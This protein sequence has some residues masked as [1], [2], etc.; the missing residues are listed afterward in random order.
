M[1]ILE[2]IHRFSHDGNEAIAYLRYW[3]KDNRPTVDV[4]VVYTTRIN[5][6]VAEATFVQGIRTQRFLKNI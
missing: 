2:N 1:C 3:Y 4:H 5:P 6:F